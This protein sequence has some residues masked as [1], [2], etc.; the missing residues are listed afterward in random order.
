MV[1]RLLSSQYKGSWPAR[2]HEP[3]SICQ[4]G[5]SRRIDSGAEAKPYGDILYSRIPIVRRIASC[6]VE[7]TD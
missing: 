5:N 7:T 3:F 1:V 2:D 4:G 6:L